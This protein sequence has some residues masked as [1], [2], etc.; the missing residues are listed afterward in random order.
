MDKELDYM[1]L[2]DDE[3]EDDYEP[4][5]PPFAWAGGKSR[6]KDKLLGILPQGRIYVEPFG[7][8]GA[9]LLAR[10]PVQTE[11]FNDR[12]S[13]IVDFYKCLKDPV[14]SEQ[15]IERLELATYSREEWLECKA[16]W[17]RT[18]DIVERSARWYTMLEYSF[19]N[20][21]RNI[22]RTLTSKSKFAGKLQNKLK[23]FPYIHERMKNVFLENCSWEC[24]FRDY[25]HE[26]TVIYCDPPYLETDQSMYSGSTWTMQDQAKLLRAIFNHKGYAALSSYPCPIN[27]AMPWDDVFE[28]DVKVSVKGKHNK[29]DQSDKRLGAKEVLYV[30]EV[31]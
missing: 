28:W 10:R 9:I 14:L 22:G 5:K 11:V 21:G 15:L 12:F 4:I 25:N 3:V 31:Y 16:T 7:G 13:A 1:S 29:E 6:S 17:V 20:M 23:L 27:E 19:S 24:M 18:T 2:Y 8:S 30:K 26:D